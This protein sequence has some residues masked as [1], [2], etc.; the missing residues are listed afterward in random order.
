MAN[1]ICEALQLL[2]PSC[3]PLKKVPFVY[4]CQPMLTTYRAPLFL[5]PFLVISGGMEDF[6][7]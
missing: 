4:C 3:N 6:C 5:F 1:L 2:L 7:I